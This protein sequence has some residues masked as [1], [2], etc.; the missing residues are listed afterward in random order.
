LRGQAYLGML[1]DAPITSESAAIAAAVPATSKSVSSSSTT[2]LTNSGNPAHGN[3][4]ANSSS[5]PPTAAGEPPII[6]I[7]G[8]NPAIIDVGDSYQDLGATITGPTDADKNL[9]LKYFLNGALVSDILIDTT[10]SLP[11][12]DFAPSVFDYN[13]TTTL[14]TA[15]SI[16]PMTPAPVF[17]QQL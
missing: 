3:Q 16:T 1:N 7:N 5:T 4:N 6:Q 13:S 14:Q 17:G 12:I 10:S 11:L 15:A 2:D 8:D 9:G